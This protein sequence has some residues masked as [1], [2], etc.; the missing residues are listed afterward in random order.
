[1]NKVVAH[2][3][4]NEQE[5]IKAVDTFPQFGG[6][7]AFIQKAKEMTAQLHTLTGEMADDL[8]SLD[9]IK[10]LLKFRQIME[11]AR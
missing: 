6:D 7:L 4:V 8:S 11:T 10:K 5:K 1:L 3:A 2:Q 9:W